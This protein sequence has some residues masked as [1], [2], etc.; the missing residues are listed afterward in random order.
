MRMLAVKELDLVTGGSLPEVV[1]T[2]KRSRP[3]ENPV[4]PYGTGFDASDIY[5]DEGGNDVR[6]EVVVEA[7]RM[8]EQ[9]KLAYDKAKQRAEATLLF[10]EAM[11]IG[12]WGWLVASASKAGQGALGAVGYLTADGY[13]DETR[14][15][16]LE[17]LTLY[18]FTLDGLDGEYDGNVDD[19]KYRLNL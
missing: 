6:E 10:L 16:L 12:V 5:G 15:K 7:P 14:E 8:T 19:E 17:G 4:D 3:G 1:V 9:E 13:F 11:G 18:E 2:G